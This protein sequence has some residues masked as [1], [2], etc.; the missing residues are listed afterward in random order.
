MKTATLTEDQLQA[1][2][3]QLA[4]N[5]YPQTRRLLFHIPNGGHRSKREAMKF[6]AIGVVAGMPDLCFLWN[7][8]AHFMELKT[9]RGKVSPIQKKVHEAIT[10]QNI[11]VHIVRSV[12]EFEFLIK[13]ILNL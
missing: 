11:E 13:S 2:C 5:Q 7:G 4:W 1:K 9:S 6:K 12:G 3:F 10:A 8:K